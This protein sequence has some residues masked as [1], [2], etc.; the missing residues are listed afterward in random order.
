MRELA[1]P[2]T[3][4][5]KAV[6]SLNT[7]DFQENEKQKPQEFSPADV[8]P[9][10]VDHMNVNDDLDG[11]RDLKLHSQSMIEVDDSDKKVEILEG[12]ERNSVLSKQV[13]EINLQ[14]KGMKMQ[15]IHNSVPK[16]ERGE[17]NLQMSGIH[18]YSNAARGMKRKQGAEESS[19]VSNI[20]KSN[21]GN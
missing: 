8:S 12:T 17:D 9:I 7:E 11:S 13:S 3:S 19:R 16:K 14:Q 5:R 21:H 1:A 4:G 20:G 18:S 15:Q 2:L 10:Q 6:A